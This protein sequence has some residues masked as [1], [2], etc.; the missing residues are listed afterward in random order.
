MSR[1]DSVETRLKEMLRGQY[2]E[3]EKKMGEEGKGRMEKVAGV[4]DGVAAGYRAMGDRFRA[5][6]GRIEA[7]ENA[8]GY[9]SAQ[10][11]H[12]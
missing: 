10:E 8:M 6:R 2:E 1:V 3:M 12:I 11:T 4:T 5:M 7:L 9:Y